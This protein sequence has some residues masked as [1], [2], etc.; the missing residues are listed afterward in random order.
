MKLPAVRSFESDKDGHVVRINQFRDEFN[1][2]DENTLGDYYSLKLKTKI[3]EASGE[4]GYSVGEDL[5]D[6]LINRWLNGVKSPSIRDIE[7]MVPYDDDNGGPSAVTFRGWIKSTD[8]RDMHSKLIGDIRG[9]VK[10]F[11]IDLGIDVMNNLSDFLAL[12]PTESTNQIRAAIDKV[13]KQTEATGNPEYTKQIE[14]YLETIHKAGGIDKV[15]PSEGFTFS[16]K[17]K[18]TGEYA[19]YKLVGG[20]SDLNNLIGFFKYKRA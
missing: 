15:V 7:K 18:S 10:E 6:I 4:I 16:Y 20:F 3:L 1:L 19:V 5:L 13:V 9:G 2:T 14:K 11:I 17:K 12:N 8:T